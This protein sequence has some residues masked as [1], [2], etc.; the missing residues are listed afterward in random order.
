M[1]LGQ[2]PNF[3]MTLV[4]IGMVLG[5]GLLA[6][7]SFKTSLTASSAEANATGQVITSM[8]NFSAQMP[9]VGT[10]AGVA[11]IIAVVVGALWMGGK[12]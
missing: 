10:I 5:A 7:G 6:L 3:V 8:A 9:T 11:V 2:I 12:K 4:F 1:Q